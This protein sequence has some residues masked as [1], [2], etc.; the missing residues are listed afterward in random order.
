MP[1]FLPRKRSALGVDSFEDVVHDL[2]RG[3]RLNDVAGKLGLIDPALHR[4]GQAVVGFPLELIQVL[5]AFQSQLL[6]EYELPQRT[7]SLK[8]VNDLPAVVRVRRHVEH[9][10]RDPQEEGF[11]QAALSPGRPD[12]T[13][14]LKIGLQVDL[15][16]SNPF[17]H[18]VHGRL[19][20]RNPDLG[21]IEGFD[22]SAPVFGLEVF[23]LDSLALAF[24]FFPGKPP[25]ILGSLRWSPPPRSERRAG[26][27]R[28][29]GSR[30]ISVSRGPGSLGFRAR[31]RSSSMLMR[32]GLRGW[33]AGESVG[34]CPVRGNGTSA[35]GRCRRR[36]GA[37]LDGGRSRVSSP[38]FVGS[39][40]VHFAWIWDGFPT[41]A[42]P[43]DMSKSA[44]TPHRSSRDV[45]PIATASGGAGSGPGSSRRHAWV[46]IPAVRIA[47][48]RGSTGVGRA[49]LTAAFGVSRVSSRPPAATASS[50][51]A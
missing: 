39:N 27:G 51:K 12:I 10:K 31:G 22:D 16:F 19:L 24:S 46:G 15:V 42:Y 36:R 40:R 1:D 29:Q 21:G 4:A 13:R 3:A 41:I 11:D 43:F 30:T 38:W 26:V 20:R 33:D 7:E 8:S 49:S 47:T 48:C 14:P 28:S 5:Q 45:S 34:R 9:R 6:V 23:L 44:E 37:A 35:G 32:I 17:D 18:K 2:R 25:R 50:R